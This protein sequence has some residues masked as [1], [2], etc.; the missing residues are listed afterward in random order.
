[1][2][3]LARKRAEFKGTQFFERVPQMLVRLAKAKL[4][5]TLTF[6][7]ML[8]LLTLLTLLTPLIRLTRLPDLPE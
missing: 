3:V 8:A 2:D 7:S 1:M 5:T 6:L 4:V